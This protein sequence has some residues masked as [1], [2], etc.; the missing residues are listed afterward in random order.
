MLVRTECLDFEWAYILPKLAINI[1][2][3]NKDLLDSHG[4]CIQF[5]RM[6]RFVLVQIDTKMHDQDFFDPSLKG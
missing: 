2:G 3:Q 1:R 4:M 6:F 5:G